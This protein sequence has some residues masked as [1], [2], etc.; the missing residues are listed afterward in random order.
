MLFPTQL[1]ANSPPPRRAPVASCAFSA[2]PQAVNP[3]L[4]AAHLAKAGKR[5]TLMVPW[6]HPVEQAMIF[7]NGLSFDTPAEQEQHIRKWLSERAGLPGD[8]FRLG[9]YP[10]RYDVE[11]GSIL[12]LGDIT[13]LFDPDEADIC[14]LEEPEHLTWYHSG[15]NWRHRFKLVVGVV[16]TNYIYYAKSWSSG[17]PLIAEALKGINQLV[18][19]AYCDKVIKLSDT[20]QPLPRAIVCNVHGVRADFLEI[21]RKAAFPSLQPRFRKGAYFLGKALWAKGHQLLFDYLEL[22]RGRGDEPTHI[23]IYG[24][25]EDLEDI[26]QAAEEKQLDLT[27]HGPTDHAGAEIRDYKVFVNPSQSEV[28]STTIAEALAMGKFV[29]IQRHPSNDFFMPF[30]NTLAYDTPEEF[31]AQLK[32]ALSSMP[33]PLSP[34]ERKTLSWEGATE[35]FLDAV[36]DTTH[37]STLPTLGDDAARLFHQGIQK[38]GYFGDAMRYFSGAGPVSRQ[39]WMTKYRDAAVTELVEISVQKNPPQGERAPGTFGFTDSGPA[40]SF[41]SF[42]R[43]RVRGDAADMET[44]EEAAEPALEPA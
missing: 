36:T 24:K 38:G 12:P 10:G 42:F 14:V 41:A 2:R 19:T 29:V 5:V 39:A 37:T 44:T 11:R 32:Y 3:L 22:E 8:N 1:S 27:F 25:G 17:G 15:P 28:L 23:D 30:R 21:G 9:F 18:C 31:L 20:L 13:R 33:A 43:T 16:H 26:R 40:S 6:V 7:P 34:E 4:R 35:R